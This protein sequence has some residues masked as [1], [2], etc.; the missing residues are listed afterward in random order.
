MIKQDFFSLPFFD[1][2]RMENYDM[3]DFS[4]YIK[5]NYSNVD[6]INI[7]ILDNSSNEIEYV[8]FYKEVDSE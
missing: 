3:C 8:I 6:V 5:D 1:M 2:H 4:K 7:Q